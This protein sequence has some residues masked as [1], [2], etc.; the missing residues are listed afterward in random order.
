MRHVTSTGGLLATDVHKPAAGVAD[1]GGG[2]GMGGGGTGGGEAGGS[3][4]GGG[5]QGGSSGAAE[6]RL[7]I[8]Q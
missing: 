6:L 8:G 3:G 2:G 4:G 1:A 7:V 5:G